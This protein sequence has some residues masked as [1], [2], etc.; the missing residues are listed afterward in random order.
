MIIIIHVCGKIHFNIILMSFPSC[1]Q[2]YFIP[3]SDIGSLPRM[4]SSLL[5]I[6]VIKIVNKPIGIERTS[7]LR[8]LVQ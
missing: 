3:S 2:A 8:F 4:S 6:M 7:I 1:T 5:S